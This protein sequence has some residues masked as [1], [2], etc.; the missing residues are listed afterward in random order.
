[1][2]AHFTTEYHPQPSVFSK[3][4]HLSTGMLSVDLL[5]PSSDMCWKY[6]LLQVAAWSKLPSNSVAGMILNFIILL[7]LPL[8]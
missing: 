6:K 1:M 2:L 4:S 8:K 3:A 5:S 7:P